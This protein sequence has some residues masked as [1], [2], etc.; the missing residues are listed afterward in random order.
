MTVI[1]LLR[2]INVGGHNRLPMADLRAIAAD[3]GHDGARTHLQSGNLVLPGLGAEPA[4]VEAALATGIAE[5]TGLTVP[6]IARTGAQIHEVVATNPYPAQAAA[7]PTK[8]LVTF[9][10]A[11]APAALR[12]FDAAPHHP[13]DAHVAGTEIYLSLPSG[14]GRSKLATALHRI[15]NADAGTT[16]NWRTVLALADMSPP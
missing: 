11:P 16:R 4:E 2:G 10:P 7:D 6:I 12:A 9:L 15:P 3:R 8:V 14:I 1:A 5:R 13:E